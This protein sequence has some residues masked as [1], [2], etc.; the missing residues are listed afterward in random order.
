MGSAESGI[1]V[2]NASFA[3][4]GARLF[5]G[6]SST[7]ASSSHFDQNL[8]P[9]LHILQQSGVKLKGEDFEERETEGE[10][11]GEGTEAKKN[12]TEYQVNLKRFE[13]LCQEVPPKFSFL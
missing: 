8:I 11:A 6:N 7:S 12:T 10:N 2:N 4:S 1:Y 13:K 9:A 5:N 3:N